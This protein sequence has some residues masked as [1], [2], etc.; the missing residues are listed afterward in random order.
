M[1]D[2]GLPDPK[3]VIG[4][5]GTPR[6]ELSGDVYFSIA[7]GVA[8]TR[9]VFLG[10]IGAPDAWRDAK[11]VRIGEL[12]FGTGLNF[13]VAWRDWLEV[14]PA[15]ATFEF[16]SIEGFPPDKDTLARALSP[17]RDVGREAQALIDAWPPRVP[18][19]HR[20]IFDG[21]RVRLTLAFG[22]VADMLSQ[23]SGKM[24]AWFLDGFAPSKNPDMWHP[25]VL[26]A[27]AERTRAGGHVATFTVAGAVRRG[28]ADVGF[29]IAKRPGFGSKRECLSGLKTG[30]EEKTQS[31]LA[32]A[33]VAVIGG[34]I[35]GATMARALMARGLVPTVFDSAPASGASGNPAALIAP[36]LPRQQ[37]TQGRVMAE[38]YPFAVRYYD[39]LAGEGASV[40]LGARGSVALARNADEEDR[41]IK[42]VSAFGLP[43][44]VMQRLSA[45][46]LSAKL[47]VTVTHPGLW[48]KDAGCL[49]PVAVVTHL[50]Q[51]VET[52]ASSVHD[53]EELNF[54]AVVVCAGTGVPDVLP[55]GTWPLRANRGQISFLK[56]MSHAPHMPVTFGGYLTP[57]VDVP[58][59]GA[60]HVLGATYARHGEVPADDWHRLRDEDHAENIQALRE[61]LPYLADAEIVGGRTALRATIRDYLPLA[62][63]VRDNVWMLGG[64]G[65]RGFLTAP[66]LAECIAD[67][68][69]GAAPPLP[70]DLMAAVDPNRFKL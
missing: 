30:T 32:G 64:L 25:K 1:Q 18:G 34:G 62:G 27:I 63:H 3:I 46:A 26:T 8:E 42:A 38:S 59:G 51:G 50:L 60:G 39:G 43:D 14:A 20:L 15:D 56:P 22:E 16:V 52:E 6:S 7:G 41:Q 19:L 45:E 57:V 54:D 31:L 67:R 69:T 13:L 61:Q 4:D 9:H 37:T 33:R 12:G 21:G 24:D 58:D 2:Q 53:L 29:E 68:M 17:M 44:D 49:S 40:W 5:D 65:S 28:L 23:I 55:G 10:G 48:F 66:L 47:G 70:P 11:C 35:A 36:R